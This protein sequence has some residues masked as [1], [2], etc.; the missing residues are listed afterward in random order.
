M[1]ANKYGFRGTSHKCEPPNE[2]GIFSEC[3]HSGQCTVDVLTNETENDYGPG[4]SYT[5]DTTQL[6]TVR[7]DYHESAGMWTAFTITLTQGENSVVMSAG[8]CTYLQGM[9]W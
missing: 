4:S 8:D 2:D 7:A 6:F 1:E 9:S 5:I 3:D